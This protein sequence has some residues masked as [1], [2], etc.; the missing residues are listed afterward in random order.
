M[1]VYRLAILMHYTVDTVLRMKE[2]HYLGL[3]REY[4][5]MQ[6]N[7]KGGSGDIYEY[8]IDAIDKVRE[9]YK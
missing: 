1:G 3:W 2:R 9:R 8:E 4:N 5:N 6:N 7:P